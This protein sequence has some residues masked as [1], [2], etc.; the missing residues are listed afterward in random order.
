MKIDKRTWYVVVGGLMVI[1][2]GFFVF[3]V[4]QM[5]LRGLPAWLIVVAC[6]G[7]FLYLKSIPLKSVPQTV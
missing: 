1:G 6:A 3:L 2:A 4:R 5:V 7:L